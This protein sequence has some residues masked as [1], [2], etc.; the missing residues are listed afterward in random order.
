MKPRPVERP[1]NRGHPVVLSLSAPIGAGLL[2][3]PAGT[4][5]GRSPESAC[6]SRR[7]T[8]L[9]S[10]RCSYTALVISLISPE[11]RLDYRDDQARLT[12]AVTPRERLT[13]FAFGSYDLLAQ[14]KNGIETVLFGSEFYRV[15]GRYDVSLPGE[16]RLRWGTT[17]GF[18]Q[19]RVSDQRNA[20]DLLW[21]PRVELTLPTTHA[22]TL[23]GGLDLLF[24]GYEADPATYGDP[25]DPDVLA[26]DRLFPSRTDS[27]AG[28]WADV[29]WRVDPRFEITPGVRL[30][31]YQSNGASAVGVE[32]RLGLHVDVTKRGRLLHAVG[33]AH[34]RPSFVVPVPGLAIANL[35]GEG[36]GAPSEGTSGSL[37][38]LVYGELLPRLLRVVGS[39]PCVP[40]Q[41]DDRR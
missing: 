36:E 12:Y 26:Y 14:E 13:L 9:A 21:G 5:R 24:D 4:G 1:T 11:I 27:V 38:D 16:G 7:P 3:A 29:V 15:D 30:D 18:H 8:A 22:V 10:S 17:W 33:M 25:E 2:Q 23:R 37:E 19:T 41:R 6:A 20:R 40:E 31:L 28:A 32:P 39:G 34:Q 35:R